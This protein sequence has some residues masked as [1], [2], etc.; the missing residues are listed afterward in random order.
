MVNTGASTP[1]L[2]SRAQVIWEEDGLLT[3]TGGKLTTFRPM[4]LDAL[5]A[6]RRL[7]PAMPAPDVHARMLDPVPSVLPGTE[8]LDSAARIRLV[9][10]HADDAAALVSAAQSARGAPLRSPT[11][12]GGAPH[13]PADSIEFIIYLF[14][15]DCAANFHFFCLLTSP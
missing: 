13:A 8:R 2:E 14:T 9:G 4:A 1:S 5:D 15:I 6:A 10:R 3:I 7:W 12:K 11:P